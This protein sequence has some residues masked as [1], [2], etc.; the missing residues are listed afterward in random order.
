MLIAPHPELVGVDAELGRDLLQR[1]AVLRQQPHRLALEL[2]C[3]PTSRLGHGSPGLNRSTLTTRPHHRGKLTAA[4][5][6]IRYAIGECADSDTADYKNV[7]WMIDRLNE[8]HSE[9]FFFLS[10]PHRQLAT[11]WWQGSGAVRTA[12]WTS[13]GIRL[14]SWK[15]RLKRQ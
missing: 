15:R 6:L 10:S 3:E 1:L 7:Q 14:V 9:P 13:R 5:G 8:S 12:L 4:D 11:S 2:A